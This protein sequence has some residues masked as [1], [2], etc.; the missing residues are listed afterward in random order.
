MY[1]KFIGIDY[2]G[3][4]SPNRRRKNIC[5]FSASPDYPS[6][7]V[8][9]GFWS[10]AEVAAHLIEAFQSNERALVGI[11]H[12]FSYPLEYFNA[13]QL[14][15]WDA[16]LTH[17]YEAFGHYRHCAA[18]AAVGRELFDEFS[19]HLRLT[20][21]HSSSAKSVFN[22]NGPGVAL[23]TWVGLPWLAMLRRD[24]RDKVHFWP[25]DGWIPDPERHCVAEVY[26]S[27]FKRRY[28]SE[29]DHTDDALDAYSICRWMK[30]SQE[31]ELLSTYFNPPLSQT[32]QQ[33]ACKEGWILGLM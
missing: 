18:T 8:R 23:S 2:S 6:T 5:V 14:Q 3:A 19:T 1:H 32:H 15:D 31:A 24:F 28:Q 17:V 29:T 12:G 33:L 20:E 16:L 7:P 11:D 10:R 26:P 4:E 30:E 27:I 13:H 9:E 21:K 25:F 22:F